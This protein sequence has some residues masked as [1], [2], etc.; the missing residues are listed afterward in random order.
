MQELKIAKIFNTGMPY[1]G[2]VPRSH[3]KLLYQMLFDIK[4]DVRKTLWRVQF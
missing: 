4:T 3:G 2:N 1:L